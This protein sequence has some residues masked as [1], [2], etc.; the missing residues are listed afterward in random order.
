MTTNFLPKKPT[1]NKK[2]QDIS[3]KFAKAPYAQ[4]YKDDFESQIYS[5]VKVGRK[6][7]SMPS[8]K[9][10]PIKVN[11]YSELAVNKYKEG[12]L[13]D[14]SIMK[15]QEEKTGAGTISTTPSEDILSTTIEPPKFNTF[16]KALFSF[17]KG[18]TELAWEAGT[19]IAENIGWI[20]DYP[21]QTAF[22]KGMAWATTMAAWTYNF[23]KETIDSIPSMGEVV[24]FW[25]NPFREEED[26]VDI[27]PRPDFMKAA[28]NTD[29]IRQMSEW[30]F[31]TRLEYSD[32]FDVRSSHEKRTEIYNEM[33]THMQMAADGLQNWTL[34]FD[35]VGGILSWLG[36]SKAPL[37]LADKV[38]K[39]T[40]LWK[41]M[42]ALDTAT[43][44]A[45]GQMPKL[46][47]AYWAAALG[48]YSQTWEWI[49]EWNTAATEGAAMLMAASWLKGL[50]VVWT[51][52]WEMSA[53]G[54]K[55]LSDLYNNPWFKKGVQ[56]Y[57]EEVK[58][59]FADD[60]DKFAW[61]VWA[62]TNLLPDSKI[63]DEADEVINARKWIVE[64]DV[65][66]KWME[67]L[68]V[69]K[70]ASNT[71]ALEKRWFF[72]K[73]LDKWIVEDGDSMYT[74]I[75]RMAKLALSPE[76]KIDEVAWSI[77]WDTGI[78]LKK[79]FNFKDTIMWNFFDPAKRE[80]RDSLEG[81]RVYWKI[82]NF[83]NVLDEARSK[84][85]DLS[86]FNAYLFAKSRYFKT[87]DKD[88][89]TNIIKTDSDWAKNVVNMTKESLKNAYL[90]WEKKYWAIADDIYKQYQSL[91][92]Y[93]RSL[94]IRTNDDVANFAK[95]PYWMPD[96]AL[97]VWKSF[98]EWINKLSIKTP[99]TF[100]SS[101][102]EALDNN[103]L[104]NAYGD[105]SYR[106]EVANRIDK[107]M[108]A[109]NAWM[110]LIK[111]LKEGKK[112]ERGF[113][114]FKLY[115]DGKQVSYQWKDFFIKGVLQDD[116]LTTNPIMAGLSLPTKLLKFKTTGIWNP[117][118]Q[119]M[120]PYFEMSS[121]LVKNWVNWGK[122]SDF[123]ST[124]LSWSQGKIA[125][126]F[127][128]G[129]W[130][131]P[132]VDMTKAI[133]DAKWGDFF[134]TP[135]MKKAFIELANF[136]GATFTKGSRARIELEATLWD[137]FTR[138]SAKKT[139]FE[140]GKDVIMKM[141]DA[142][143][144][145]N[146]IEL[147]TTRL[148][149]FA[150]ALKKQWLT[151]KMFKEMAESANSPSQLTSRLE[152]AW[153]NPQKASNM[154]RNLYDYM[155]AKKTVDEAG[156]IFGYL[157]D[158]VARWPASVKRVMEDDPNMF[159]KWMW[160][161]TVAVA[162]IYSF[163]T[164]SPKKK[165][166]Y[167]NLP[168][169]IQNSPNLFFYD[170]ETNEWNYLRISKNIPMLDWTYALYNQSN[171][172]AEWK[173]FDFN[174]AFSA[175]TEDLTWVFS[176]EKKFNLNPEILPDSVNRY[177]EYKTWFN[178]KNN[179]QSFKR[180]ALEKTIP[181]EDYWKKTSN[182]AIALSRLIAINNWWEIKDVAWRKIVTWDTYSPRLI[183]ALLDNV[184]SWLIRGQWQKLMDEFIEDGRID[185][186]QTNAFI[187]TFLKKVS[188]TDF[189]EEEYN[190]TQKERWQE[191]L[192]ND[193]IKTQVRNSDDNQLAVTRAAELMGKYPRKA[194][195]IMNTL[196]DKAKLNKFEEA[197]WDKR[198]IHLSKN[199]NAIIARRLISDIED[200]VKPKDIIGQL[201]TMAEQWLIS[202]T[203]AINIIKTITEIMAEK[204]STK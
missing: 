189:D 178:L 52:G 41:S 42:V 150:S 127:V 18:A 22:A 135:A 72:N 191:E 173:W 80:I 182:F 130:K 116:K 157:S 149:M 129:L 37:L 60:I 200:W 138:Y 121:A 4:I 11:T 144:I 146:S 20:V 85:A 202:E 122:A 162:S 10:N 201:T 171:K 183:D 95:N 185:K 131:I 76:R 29:E 65:I 73:A 139:A 194:E 2:E 61:K 165:A 49:F 5:W 106:Y 111:P 204:K 31:W 192:I 128:R 77:L 188:I 197:W 15:P 193:I 66:D 152:D 32:Y 93:E 69:L 7:N 75:S 164:N 3:Y 96:K 97:D 71:S 145:G 203:K 137:E 64:Q 102:Q 35:V 57:F 67:S 114:E 169:Y 155:I 89:L 74:A 51:K 86:E 21:L 27:V 158:I 186:W 25:A 118:Y 26:K 81:T 43:T 174:K 70:N 28:E 199:S 90:A 133:E 45:I 99:K 115:E 59:T 55:Y 136:W 151:P 159:I 91:L 180:S 168:D 14:S 58:N 44:K 109:K 190:K 24:A 48:Y 161:G 82:Q 160:A 177:V 179:Y 195:S 50:G 53:W 98:S 172:A 34:W 17:T 38:G 166:A 154:A 23:A 54:R 167:E 19:T 12:S 94:G 101:W 13:L 103:T 39:T 88:V 40:T 143:D 63:I 100:L 56:S 9:F 184:D 153:F 113:V 142:L 6:E 46:G 107:L 126:K 16:D 140:K 68:E 147:Y 175:A 125:D 124:A 134:Q 104:L 112:P 120:A 110:W 163:N 79:N 119:L 78:K 117:V 132:W 187:R 83:N 84:V 62:K 181:S 198:L 156:R 30:F 176:L 1:L 87:K 47:V 108:K 123:L 33:P 92:Q 8:L 148:P 105:M 36:A 141:R 170:E 196:V